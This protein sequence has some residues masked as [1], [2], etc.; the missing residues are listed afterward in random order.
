M[1]VLGELLRVDR[2]DHALDH[3]RGAPPRRAVGRRLDLGHRQPA[4]R[5]V[6]G[7]LG[8][9]GVA[10]ARRDD[11]PRRPADLR[12]RHA[13]LAGGQ[14]VHG[15]LGPARD[16]ERAVG[17]SEARCWPKLGAGALSPDTDPSHVKTCSSASSSGSSEAST[18]ADGRCGARLDASE[19]STA[20]ASGGSAVSCT[21]TRSVSSIE[22]AI[23]QAQRALGREPLGQDGDDGAAGLDAGRERLDQHVGLVGRRDL[24][25]GVDPALAA[26]E[27]FGLQTERQDDGEWTIA[28]DRS[29][30]WPDRVSGHYMNIVINGCA[31]VRTPG[32]GTM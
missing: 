31:L 29:D 15:R 14:L 19:Q 25:H 21:A 26:D 23:C 9:R 22:R 16:A 20:A 28:C 2:E 30:A 6:D 1:Q 18:P 17:P 7:L 8:P 3:L 32:A 10:V 12:Q 11:H 13:G 24:E 27:A 5:A 4:E